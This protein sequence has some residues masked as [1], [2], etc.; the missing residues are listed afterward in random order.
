MRV[1]S[2]VVNEAESSRKSIDTCTSNTSESTC[3]QI[4]HLLVSIVPGLASR[5]HVESLGKPCLVNMM[6]NDIHLVLYLCFDSSI[7]CHNSRKCS[8]DTFLRLYTFDIFCYCSCFYSTPSY[9]TSK[10]FGPKSG[11]RLQTLVHAKLS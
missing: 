11:P 8:K 2:V 6:S 1:L 7:S 3:K 9:C 10:Q 4:S 5:M